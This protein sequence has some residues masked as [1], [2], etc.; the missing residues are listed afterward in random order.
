MEIWKDIV[1]P[2]WGKYY[3]VSSLGRIKS[4]PRWVSNGNGGWMKGET[5]LALKP[6]TVHPHL[7]VCLSIVID[8]E[9]HKKTVYAHKVAAEAFIP[10][11][12]KKH[13]FVTHKDWDYTN[14]RVSNLEWITANWNSKR[15]MIIHPENKN[16]IRET[17][18]KN[19]YYQKIKSPAR[20]HSDL[21]RNMRG[22][23]GI[24]EL[25]KLF[26]CSSATISNIQRGK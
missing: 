26:N 3:Q 23:V 17:N 6:G 18:E 25:G 24:E 9:R 22:K 2:F 10:R 20:E 1:D 11:P 12:S 7:N 8:G 19:G 21:I 13:I 15:S 14:N 5:I 16:I 4:K